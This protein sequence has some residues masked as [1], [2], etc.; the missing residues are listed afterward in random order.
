MVIYCHV[1][2]GNYMVQLRDLPRDFSPELMWVNL[3][4]INS[5]SKWCLKFRTH[6][7]HMCSSEL[8][9]VGN[10][11]KQRSNETL[12]GAEIWTS[13]SVGGHATN[14]AMPPPRP[15]DCWT[16]K[17]LVSECRL[18]WDW[19]SGLICRDIRSIFKFNLAPVFLSKNS[20]SISS[21]NS[22]YQTRFPEHLTFLSSIHIVTWIIVASFTKQVLWT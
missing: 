2:D 12:V 4:H 5:E 18:F 19:A 16:Y 15:F 6:M 22:A 11:N 21:M 7:K 8:P 17:S 14:S 1:L 3:N 20:R 9:S 10:S 13:G